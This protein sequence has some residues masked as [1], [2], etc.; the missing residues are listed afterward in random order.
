MIACSIK[1]RMAALARPVDSLDA[2]RFAMSTL[3]AIRAKEASIETDMAPIMEMYALLE[4]HL[5]P[6]GSSSSALGGGGHGGS[7]AAASGSTGGGGITKEEMDQKTVLRSS[8]RKLLDRGA[9]VATHIASCQG[10][11]KKRLLTDV[12][13]FTAEIAAFRADYAANGPMVDGLPPN[14]AL[15][16]L[17]RYQDDFELRQRKRELYNGG[18]ALFA[19]QKTPFPE[20]DEMGRELQLLDELYSLYRDV[21]GRMEVRA[22]APQQR[23]SRPHSMPTPSTTVLPSRLQE[24]QSLLWSETVTH[25]DEMAQETASF[26][27]RCKSLPKR[28]RHWPAFQ[29]RCRCCRCMLS[30]HARLV[31]ALCCLDGHLPVLSL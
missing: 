11:F 14:E 21:M 1:S 20:L 18:E 13:A 10:A 12:R 16:R 27:A 23:A 9:E 19:L 28:V 29:V 30:Y 8:W 15:E 24:W 6:T 5:H 31:A 4:H 25:I 3:A 2:L 22:A 26:A 17:R 7:G